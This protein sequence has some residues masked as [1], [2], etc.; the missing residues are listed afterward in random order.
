MDA[1]R[2]D[3]VARFV[4]GSSSRRSL[5][6]L[7]AA[8][9]A[10]LTAEVEA[11]KCSPCRKKKRGKCRRRKPN[12]TPCEDG[13]GVCQRGSCACGDGPPCPSKQ[14]CVHGSCFPQGTCPAGTRTCVPTTGTLCGA[15]CFCALSAEGATVC[16]ESE[17]QCILLPDCETSAECSNCQSSADCAPG[18]ACVDFGGC[19]EGT[20]R[21]TPVPA[22]TRICA[23]PCFD[24][25]ASAVTT[26]DVTV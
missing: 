26:K 6:G 1:F 25:D 9:G 12:G 23:S 19:C 17:G 22:G 11:K 21:E 2:F 4:A 16:F 20:L 3:A 8:L 18:D 24:P 14:V 13:R 7:G 15:D 5:L 10:S